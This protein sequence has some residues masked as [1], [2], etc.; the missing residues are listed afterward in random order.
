MQIALLSLQFDELIRF[1]LVTGWLF[2]VML[3]VIWVVVRGKQ[4]SEVVS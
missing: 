1:C 2:V 4:R 3:G